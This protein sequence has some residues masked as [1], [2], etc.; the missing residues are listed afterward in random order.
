MDTMDI[1]AS[2]LKTI[3]EAFEQL[4]D[5]KLNSEDLSLQATRKE[6]EGSYTFVLFPFLRVTKSSPEQSGEKIGN[7]LIDNHPSVADF[8]VVKGFLNISLSS[9]FWIELL[10]KM[11]EQ[12]TPGY[13]EPRNQR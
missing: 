10:S 12:K 3:T 4:F 11:R 1:Q 6:F 13:F 2:I 7:F 5:H 8:N 9:A